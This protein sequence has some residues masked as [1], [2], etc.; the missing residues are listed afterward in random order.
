[1]PS[2]GVRSHASPSFPLLL[3][4]SLATAAP[5]VPALRCHSTGS[6][7]LASRGHRL[8]VG[9]SPSP[10]G[11]RC[12]EQRFCARDEL[13]AKA[14]ISVCSYQWFQGMLPGSPCL[15]RFMGD[16]ARKDLE[17]QPRDC[18]LWCLYTFYFGCS[19]AYFGAGVRFLCVI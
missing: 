2:S 8:A 14:D 1:M 10:R 12:C 16:E 5:A 11:R 13:S 3:K 9:T 7:C 15:S 18:Q 6:S 4:S 17:E 19:Q